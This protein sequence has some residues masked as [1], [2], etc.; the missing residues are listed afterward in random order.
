MGHEAHLRT[1]AA[2]LLAALNRGE[3]VRVAEANGEGQN[4]GV[5]IGRTTQPI[6]QSRESE[7]DGSVCAWCGRPLQARRGGSPKRFCEPEHRMA[8]WSAL[9]RWGEH[10]VASGMLT[11]SDIKK[12]APAACTLLSEGVSPTGDERPAK[13]PDEAADLLHALLAVES[14]GWHSLAAAMSEELFRSLRRW[15]AGHL[16]EIHSSVA[17]LVGSGKHTIVSR[18]FTKVRGPAYGT[19]SNR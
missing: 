11:I 6:L 2:A 1:S 3:D 4:R 18:N 5:E 16:A 13:L 8:F 17:T 19:P 14:D 9:R 15:H 12:G 7:A 10:A